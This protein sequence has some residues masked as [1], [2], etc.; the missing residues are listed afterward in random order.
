[1]HKPRNVP[2]RLPG[3]RVV[4]AVVTVLALALAYVIVATT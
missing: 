1:M 3:D 4:L 2:P